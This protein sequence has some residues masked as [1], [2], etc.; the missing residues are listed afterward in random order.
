M[1][2]GAAGDSVLQRSPRQ[3]R[4]PPDAV[5]SAAD[6]DQALL[7]FH[8][9][10]IRPRPMSPNRDRQALHCA[11]RPKAAQEIGAFHPR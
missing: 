10:L 7:E 5:R 6:T 4:F 1:L 2:A 8:K 11:G 9:L 3:I